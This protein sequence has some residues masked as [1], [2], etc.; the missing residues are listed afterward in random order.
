MIPR[1]EF[2]TLSLPDRRM[3]PDVYLAKKK[4]TRCARLYCEIEHIGRHACFV[5]PGESIYQLRYNDYR[6]T[7]CQRGIDSRGCRSADHTDESDQSLTLVIPLIYY[8]YGFTLP[9][10]AAI[11]YDSRYDR[12][13]VIHL[14]DECI[15]IG[16]KRADL[17]LAVESSSILSMT[18][19]QCDASQLKLEQ[20]LDL[21]WRDELDNQA[22]TDGTKNYDIPFIIVSRVA[23]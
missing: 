14:G 21:N 15:N 20:A 8:Q 3:I 16:D 4:C 18:Y 7:C 12:R 6:Y 17:S 5:H 2:S 10:Q 13:H 9:L 19:V 22:D 11:I 1:R 23:I